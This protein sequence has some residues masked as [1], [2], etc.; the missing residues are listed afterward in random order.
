MGNTILAQEGIFGLGPQT[1]K[2]SMASTFYRYKILQTDA[3]AVEN[4][5][6]SALEVGGSPFPTGAYKAGAFFG[7]VVSLQPRLEGD[8]G[9]ILYAACGS[10]STLPDT[11]A[12]GLYT[13]IF[14]PDPNAYSALKWLSA[15]ILTP[16]AVS[17]QELGR[18]GQDCRISQLRL[19]VP[20][21]DVVT[22]QIGLTGRVPSLS[23]DVS[24]W[25]WAD[26][27]EDF[28]SVP[29]SVAG[30]FQIPDA[31][32]QPALGAD[33][34]LN[35]V[36]NP[37]QREMIIGEYHPDDLVA[38]TRNLQVNFIHKYPNP[39]LYLELVTNSGTGASIAW[40]PVI[41]YKSMNLKV[42]SPGNIS[43][44]SYP[45]SLEIKATKLS[46]APEGAPR[47][48]GGDMLAVRYAGTAQEPA[49]D[50]YFEFRLVNEVAS[51]TWPT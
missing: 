45:Y 18:I 49:S 19:I 5:R 10:V 48:V 9:W 38:V 34:M 27:F 43:G 12:T 35:N 21:N 37:V 15:R 33:V 29:I 32:S 41:N 40:S 17:G 1:A 28:D 44:Q 7:G 36:L 13:H 23:D 24:G 39:D 51:Y 31:T 14:R 3:G 16:G 26:D 2:E 11:P 8:I 4:L 22:A 30:H 25:T 50:N 42:E 6:Q 20:Q 46:W 47:L